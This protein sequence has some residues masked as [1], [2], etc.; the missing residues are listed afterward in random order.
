MPE[1]LRKS[2]ASTNIIESAFSVAEEL[3]RRVKRWLDGDHRERWAGS[4][5]LLAES[6]FRRVKGYRE[7]PQLVS[8]LDGY[9]Y[10]PA[11]HH[12]PIRF[13]GLPNSLA[14]QDAR[15]KV[16]APFVMLDRNGSVVGYNTL[17][18]YS[19]HLGELPEAVAK[20]LPRY[21]LS[22]AT[23][24]G[25]LAVSKEHRGLNLGPLL[26]MDALERSLKNTAEVASVGVV[27]EALDDSARAFYRHH[28]FTPLLE[29][30]NKLSLA[31]AT[32]E[33]A[34]KAFYRDA[35]VSFQPNFLEAD[36]CTA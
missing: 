14:G 34:L 13:S 31:M 32:I 5:L 20:K 12:E 28:E 26:L 19:V 23:L 22:P 7:I 2:L 36:L 25:R 3:C 1:R 11:R 29:H 10:S 27:I 4:A 33:K 16:A 35:G 18:A 6:K 9:L 17:S 24:L 15:R 30:S 21:P 8:A